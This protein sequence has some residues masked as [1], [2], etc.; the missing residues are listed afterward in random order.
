MNDSTARGHTPADTSPGARWVEL[1]HFDIGSADGA[2][3]VLGVIL[4]LLALVYLG[5][6]RLQHDTEGLV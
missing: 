5:A 3:L 1:P 2:V 6:R 4:A